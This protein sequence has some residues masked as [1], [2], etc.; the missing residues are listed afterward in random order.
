MNMEQNKIFAAILVAGIVA[1]L[2]G[3]IAD[4]AVSPEYPERDAVSIDV[5]VIGSANAAEAD[6]PS[7]PEPILG[8]IASADVAKGEKLS[9]ACAACHSFD[10]GGPN[11][12]GP[13]LYGV[14]GS[15]KGG[16][17]GFSYSAGMAEKGGSWGYAELN[18]FLWKPKAYIN[19]T[20]MNFNGLKK[21]E[22]R[23][24][25]IA[26]LRTQA[27]SPAAM[28]SDA[29]IAAEAE[30]SAPEAAEEASEAVEEAAEPAAH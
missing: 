10:Q 8:M 5:A 15:S 26:W 2:S 28:P 16:K 21:P 4:N 24:A 17:A 27:A 18:E 6:K 13:N 30:A 29:D 7:G 12:V 23:A 20:K 1:M 14:V 22:D 25:M 3:F 9:K 11:K 19:G